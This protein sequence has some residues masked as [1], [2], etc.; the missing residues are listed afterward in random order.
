[1][2]RVILTADEEC[3]LCEGTGVRRWRD[4]AAVVPSKQMRAVC[5]CV[6]PLHICIGHDLAICLRREDLKA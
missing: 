1:M 2:A 5:T 4:R 3:K 6:E